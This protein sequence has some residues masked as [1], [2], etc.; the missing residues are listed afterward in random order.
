MV[1][2]TDKIR[3]DPTVPEAFSIRGKVKHALRNADRSEVGNTELDLHELEAQSHYAIELYKVITEISQMFISVP[4]EELDTVIH[5]A[6]ERIG[7]HIDADRVYWFDRTGDTISN[8]HEWCGDGIFETLEQNQ[9]LSLSELSGFAD[10]ML[11]DETFVISDTSTLP[12]E[13]SAERRLFESQSIQS[14]LVVPVEDKENGD[15]F[16]GFV[17][18]DSVKSER[19]WTETEVLALRSLGISVFQALQHRKERMKHEADMKQLVDQLT[20]QAEELKRIATHDE[21]TG[22]YTRRYLMEEFPR[23]LAQAD[24]H[25]HPLS[26]IMMDIDHF[27][28]VNDNH[29]HEAGDRVLRNLSK[30]LMKHVR[31]EDI[32]VRWGGEEIFIVLPET[33]IDKAEKLAERIRS[34]IESD[35]IPY[36]GHGVEITVSMGVANLKDGMDKDELFKNADEA[37]Y[38]AKGDGRNRVEVSKSM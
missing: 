38:K 34:I 4:S 22:L 29:G 24:R 20:E 12:D 35:E 27:K 15:N 13:M 25:N 37:L 33:N 18:F 26:V 19:E 23:I 6:F 16:V 9:Q 32:V 17:G 8:T 3:L 36:N 10:F 31:T 21:L 2:H 11:N 7:R 14:L 5:E 28:N 30:L 1:E